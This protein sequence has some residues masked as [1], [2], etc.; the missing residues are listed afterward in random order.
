MSATSNPITPESFQLAIRELDL[1]LLHRES[2]RLQNSIYH[3]Q[4]SNIALEE[5]KD[6][7]DC[8]IA[9]RENLETIQRQQ[10]RVQM[11]RDE[12]ERRGFGAPCG[13]RKEEVDETHTHANGVVETNGVGGATENGISDSSAGG[14]GVR[15]DPAVE[16]STG[17]EEEGIYL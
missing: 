9:I 12:V 15:Q 3:L 5:V 8:A 14:N 2:S 10:E 4:R 16:S 17:E 7:E 13:E 6:D 1:E 11:I